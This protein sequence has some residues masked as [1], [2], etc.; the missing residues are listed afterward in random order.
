METS[1]RLMFVIHTIACDHDLSNIS[2]AVLCCEGWY[3]G[4]DSHSRC[5]GPEEQHYR[6]LHRSRC[7]YEHDEDRLVRVFLRSLLT[8]YLTF[9]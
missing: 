2:V 8:S 1:D 9:I 7:W 6:K 4:L 3:L 5:R